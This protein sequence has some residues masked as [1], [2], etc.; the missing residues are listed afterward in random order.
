MKLPF[1]AAPNGGD[2]ADIGV[3]TNATQVNN[4][5]VRYSGYKFAALR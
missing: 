3:T 5:H 2:G 1:Q 4:A